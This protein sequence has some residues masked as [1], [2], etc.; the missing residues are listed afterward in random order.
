MFRRTKC[1]HCKG[2]LE[3][4]QRIHPACIE[5]YA[6][7][8]A[9][10]AK[11]TAEKK[12]RA[13]AKVQRASIKKSLIRL[14]TLSEWKAIA[15]KETNSL[16]ILRDKDLPCISCG[17]VHSE[18]WHAGHY[19]SRGSAPHLALD[20]RNIHKQC[21]QCNMHLHGNLIEYRKGLVQRM[22]ESFVIELEGDQVSRKYTKHDMEFIAQ[23]RRQQKKELEREQKI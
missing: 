11:R 22:G 15:Q 3:A 10:K 9:E 14:R 12:A 18:V 2:K 7:A 13:E 21:P 6:D 20:L 17:R 1:P 16:V 4:G 5:G 23:E 19:R 8:Q